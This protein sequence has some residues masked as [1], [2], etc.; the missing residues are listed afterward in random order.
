VGPVGGEGVEDLGAYCRA[1]EAHLCA[2][3]GGHLVRIAGPAF[4]RVAGWASRG[5]P[6]KIVLRG[7]DRFVERYESKGPRR[8]PALVEFC[9]A[10]ILD[11][12]DEWRRAVGVAA[13][14]GE[15]T[16]ASTE[17]DGAGA[18][19][20]GDSKRGRSLPRHLERVIARLT[21]R[22]AAS[23]VTGS[24]ATTIDAA[25]RE[26][27]AIRAGAKSLRGDARDRAVRRLAEIDRD[28]LD[29]AR[30]EAGSA[31]DALRAEAAAE[32]APFK[33]RMPEPAYQHALSEAS[34]RLVRERSGLPVVSFD[35]A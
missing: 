24:L 14:S 4:E 21:A 33:A 18:A 13:W 31:R 30:G 1:I 17:A 6:V 25:V 32:L 23:D 26:L 11:V 22:R 9:E 20:G 34:D 10:D 19:E 3:N 28:L 2:R 16:E 8:R 12:F 27:D 29:C 7:I 5:I 35:A 15:E